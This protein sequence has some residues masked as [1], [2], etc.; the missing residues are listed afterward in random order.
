MRPL[1]DEDAETCEK[2][3][4]QVTFVFVIPD[5][6]AE[7]R[8]FGGGITSTTS[9]R[10]RP[11]WDQSRGR[12]SLPTPIPGEFLFF[13]CNLTSRL[14]CTVNYGLKNMSRLPFCLSLSVVLHGFLEYDR[15]GNSKVKTIVIRP[16]RFEM[17][18]KPDLCISAFPRMGFY[19]S[20]NESLNTVV[21]LRVVGH[22][23]DVFMCLRIRLHK[24]SLA[25]D[26]EKHHDTDV[27]S[28][29]V[30]RFS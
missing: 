20:P 30:A 25:V 21:D 18:L 28:S 4:R 5:A 19:P 1:R 10:G 2:R 7:G 23:D 11:R 26:F 27:T 14:R 22:F 12:I 17:N 24:V 29:V 9:A 15:H 8:R 6:D 16:P 13:N 3:S